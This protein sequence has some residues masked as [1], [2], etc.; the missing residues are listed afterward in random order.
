MRL[1]GMNWRFIRKGRDPPDFTLALAA[2][3]NPCSGPDERLF[4]GKV[5]IDGLSYYGQVRADGKCY[6]AKYFS[7]MRFDVVLT[8]KNFYIFEYASPEPRITLFA[9][10]N[11]QHAHGPY[12]HPIRDAEDFNFLVPEA[13]RNLNCE[14]VAR[15]LHDDR[16]LP[17][18][19]HVKTR[20]GFFL[21]RN[22]ARQ[23]QIIKIDNYEYDLL[24]NW[25]DTL[26]WK[27]HDD[28]GDHLDSKNAFPADPE[29]PERLYFGRY[30][31]SEGDVFYG[32]VYEDGLCCS[33][34]YDDVL[35]WSSRFDVL[36]YK[37]HLHY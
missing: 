24:V 23:Q 15:I 33:Q 1:L 37:E 19:V 28:E 13:Y 22:E 6:V 34:F 4:Y 25:A 14:L 7:A 32:Q 11:L 17:G 3:A 18:F 27:K 26:E 16:Y 8:F 20:I 21:R 35:L 10:L 30:F 36:E 2:D 31:P 9:P 29:A 5:I 12:F